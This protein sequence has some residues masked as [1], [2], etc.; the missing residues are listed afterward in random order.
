MWI[1]D[2]L[3]A[4][5][6]RVSL[7]LQITVLKTV[8]VILFLYIPL[9]YLVNK[10][11]GRPYHFCMATEACLPLTLSLPSSNFCTSPPSLSARNFPPPY[12]RIFCDP[13]EQSGHFSEACI[14]L[15][16]PVGSNVS[17]F[18]G[19]EVSK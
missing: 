11:I 9:V 18:Q 1:T 3:K 4:I 6:C 13:L 12:P 2:I 8:L 7:Y 16:P 10:N 19:F 14:L 5:A 15:I 17:Q